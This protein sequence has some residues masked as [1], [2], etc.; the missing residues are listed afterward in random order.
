MQI[1]LLVATTSFNFLMYS[2]FSILNV[3][4]SVMGMNFVFLLWFEK[5]SLGLASKLEKNSHFWL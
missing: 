5:T 3:D 2:Q 4:I 1:F